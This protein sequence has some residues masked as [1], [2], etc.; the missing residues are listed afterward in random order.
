MGDEDPKDPDVEFIGLMPVAPANPPGGLAVA[1]PT[2][3]AIAPTPIAIAPTPAAPTPAAAATVS[4][5]RGVRAANQGAHRAQANFA[6]GSIGNPQVF[7]AFVRIN[8]NNDQISLLTQMNQEVARGIANLNSFL[9][10]E[11]ER[12]QAHLEAA[13]AGANQRLSAAIAHGRPT[14]TLLQPIE[15]LENQLDAILNT[16]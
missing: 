3:V 2:I 14:T 7:P 10:S 15:C 8:R 12:R 1:A 5:N 16:I 13:L 6:V 11:D 4:A 9:P